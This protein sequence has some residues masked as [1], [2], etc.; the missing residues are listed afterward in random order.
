VAADQVAAVLIE[1]V[2]GE[3][4][5]VPAPVAYL[6]GLR[7]L[8]DQHGILLIADEVQSGFARTGRWASYEHYGI[9][10]DLS[11]W[12]KSM[13]GGMP[14]AAVLGK[15]AVMDKVAPG[16]VGGTYGGNPV[17]CAAALATIAEMERLDLNSRA[18][19]VGDR[20]RRRFLE[21][22]T[23]CPAIGDVRGLGAMIGVEFVENGDPAKPLSL[24]P[25]VDRCVARGVLIIPAGPHGNVLRVRAPLV[26]T[27]EQLARG[28]AIVEAEVLEAFGAA[29]GRPAAAA[30][31]A[32][33]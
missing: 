12:A 16:T 18:N 5:F 9:V 14:I 25:V 13:G 33:R 10:P 27:D 31:A 30:H 3:G 24:G 23:R 6:Q 29:A 20:V 1:P 32:A 28:L 17:A 26:I 7:T 11:T 22:Q 21:L 19:H 4:G 2:Q 15:A 8:C